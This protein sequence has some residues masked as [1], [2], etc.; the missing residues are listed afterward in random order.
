MTAQI[1]QNSGEATGYVQAGGSLVPHEGLMTYQSDTGLGLGAG[2]PPNWQP[3]TQKAP[4]LV[5][6][7][8][9]GALQYCARRGT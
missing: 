9:S 2:D 4:D 6:K 8:R 5:N 3:D 7:P 1:A